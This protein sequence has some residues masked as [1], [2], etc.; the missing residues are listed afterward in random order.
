[1]KKT[2]LDKSCIFNVGDMVYDN[3]TLNRNNAF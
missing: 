1:M 3:T 2:T